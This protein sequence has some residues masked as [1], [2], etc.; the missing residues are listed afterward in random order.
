MNIE[1]LADSAKVSPTYS[2]RVR[3]KVVGMDIV[4]FAQ[5]VEADVILRAMELKDVVE[6]LRQRAFRV[7][8]IEDEEGDNYYE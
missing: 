1:I 5:K 8:E 4:D 3:I 2:K 7:E 6:Y